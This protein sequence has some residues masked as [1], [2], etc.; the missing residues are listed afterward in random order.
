MFK[1]NKDKLLVPQILAT[2]PFDTHTELSAVWVSRSEENEITL[3]VDMAG[4]VKYT[5]STSKRT[6]SLNVL[7]SFCNFIFEYVCIKCECQII[8]FS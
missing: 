6:V 4:I 7:A 2:M 3:R 5:R 1:R 8:K